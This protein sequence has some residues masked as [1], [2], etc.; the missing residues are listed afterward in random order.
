MSSESE[1][2]TSATSSPT[3]SSLPHR[4]TTKSQLSSLA[5]IVKAQV[6]LLVSNLTDENYPTKT[7]E[8]KTVSIPVQLSGWEKKK[9]RAG[10]GVRRPENW[11]EKERGVEKRVVE[12]RG[13]RALGGGPHKK[14]L[15]HC[16]EAHTHIRTRGN[17]AVAHF[18][19]VNHFP[20]PPFFLAH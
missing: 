10:P 18:F 8:I 19:F 9:T 1:I 5:R 20:F 17:T 2:S 12:E 14:G 13:D 15:F 11:T 3:S 4:A 16:K 6:I 7:V